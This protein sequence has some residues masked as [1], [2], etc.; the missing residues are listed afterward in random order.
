[1]N[2]AQ[3]AESKRHADALELYATG[4]EHQRPIEAA[5]AFLRSIAAEPQGEPVAH[6]ID[7][8]NCKV[9]W[10]DKFTH[11]SQ[12][13]ANGTPLYLRPAQTPMTDEEL[14]GAI[15]RGWCSPENEAK[16]MDSDLAFAIAKEVRSAIERKI[17]GLA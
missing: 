11:I 14:L 13:P 3:R 10:S 4:D 15:A 6:V 7:R 17:L 9:W 12:A 5:E 1:M 2:E 8:D 16:E